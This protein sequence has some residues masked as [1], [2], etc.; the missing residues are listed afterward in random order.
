KLIL[1]TIASFPIIF[2]YAG[3]TSILLPKVIAGIVGFGVLNLKIF[4]KIYMSMLAVFCTNSINIYAGINGLEVGQ[5]II[6][7]IS[8][9]FYNLLEINLGGSIDNNLFS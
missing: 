9:I 3:S 2:A 1:P 6:I 4:F 7:G 8:I 5:S